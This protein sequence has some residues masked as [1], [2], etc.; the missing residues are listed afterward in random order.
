MSR[1]SGLIFEKK[2][3]FDI[4]KFKL[5]SKAYGNEI[6]KLTIHLSTSLRFP[7]VCVVNE[8]IRNIMAV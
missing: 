6:K 2:A 8:E 4:F 3:N 7:G 5:G 1:G